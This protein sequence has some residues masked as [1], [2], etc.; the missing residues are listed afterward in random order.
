MRSVNWLSNSLRTLR[1]KFKAALPYVRRREHRLL[2]QRHAELIEAVDGIATP[3]AAAD[4]HVFKPLAVTLTG[5]VCLFVSF[6]DQP[7]LKVH[8]A[9]HITHLLAEGI[10]VVLVVNTDLP[11]NSIQ[12]DSEL[13]DRLS[14]VLIRQNLGFDFGAWAH[15]LRLCKDR[16]KWTRLYLVNDSIVGPLSTLAFTRVIERVRAAGADVLG[17]TE[18]LLPRRHLQ[19]YFLVFSANALRSSAFTSLFER[20]LNWPD[21]AQVIELYE[22]RLSALLE[23]AGLHCQALFP[24]LHTDPLSSDDTSIRW[25]ELVATGFPYLKTRV[26]TR[27]ARDKRIER[28]L[29]ARPGCAPHR[30]SCS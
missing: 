10:R 28:W 18:S 29:A 11:L 19:S 30:E 17:L 23:A 9:E 27:H 3:A 13:Q 5:E 14:G 21:K 2:Q 20:L 7:E 8:V 26:I 4:L 24:S 1:R 6:A 22:A 12:L 25:A 15:A 16:A